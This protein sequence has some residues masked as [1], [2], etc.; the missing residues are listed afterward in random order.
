MNLL[1][2][3]LRDQRVKNK[4]IAKETGDKK[5]KDLEQAQKLGINSI[6][7]HQGGAGFLFN[8]PQIADTITRR[9]RELFDKVLLLMTGKNF[10]Y[11]N[12]GDECEEEN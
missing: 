10:K 12:K 3:I 6:Y 11:W 8:S 2:K 5:F 9:G 1:T 7:G 4:K